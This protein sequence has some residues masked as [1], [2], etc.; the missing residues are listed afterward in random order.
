MMAVLALLA[1][2]QRPAGEQVD[3]VAPELTQQDTSASAAQDEAA[4]DAAQDEALPDAAQE[5]VTEVPAPTPPDVT[6]YYEI[7]TPMGR[8]VVHLYD[9]TPGHRDNF[10]KL[11]AEGVL[12]GTLF[13]RVMNG[14]MI[15]GGDPNSKDDDPN[16]DGGGGPGYTI[17]AEFDA[18]LIHKRGALAAARQGDQVNPERR[19]SGS[20]FY[21]VHGRQWTD[22]ELDQLELQARQENPEFSITA[23]RRTFYTSNAGTPFLD[24]SYTVFGELV[25]GFDVLDA[26]AATPTTGNYRQPPNR[27][28]EDVPMTVRPLYDYGK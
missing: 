6:N 10:R 20:Q 8:M 16:N 24:D 11:V 7:T 26:I 3:A 12:S 4:S 27:P 2:C 5:A 17:E 19:S 15:Q 18:R 22:D 14:F 13:H 23:E 25:E 1:A 28:I 9:E 21:I